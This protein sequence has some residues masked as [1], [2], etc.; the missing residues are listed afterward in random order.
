[1]FFV[2]Y[3]QM[4]SGPLS[5]RRP[6]R[7]ITACDFVKGSRQESQSF[8]SQVVFGVVAGGLKLGHDDDLDLQ[9][10]DQVAHVA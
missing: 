4:K 10:D 2:R 5:M 8:L 3:L 1:M 9:E 6:D 7:F